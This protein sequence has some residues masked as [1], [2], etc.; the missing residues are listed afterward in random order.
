MELRPLENLARAAVLDLKRAGFEYIFT[1]V[2]GGGNGPLG[3]YIY[4]HA[5]DF[6]VVDIGGVETFRL[7]KL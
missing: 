7:L 6:G 5:S 3:K 1:P 2:A 4:E